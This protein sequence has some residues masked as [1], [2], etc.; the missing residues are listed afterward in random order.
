VFIRVSRTLSELGLATDELIEV[1]RS[2]S[3]VLS[4][5]AIASAH[6]KLITD[7]HPSQFLA[8]WNS[9]AYAK[10]HVLNPREGPLLPNGDRTII[11]DLVIYDH[12]LI[13][14]ILDGGLRELSAGY[15][16]EYVE[17][18]DS[19]LEQR[20]IRINHVAFVPN[21]RCGSACRVEDSKEQPMK[22]EDRESLEE[23]VKLIRELTE[24]LSEQQRTQDCD[25]TGQ[26]ED[27]EFRRKVNSVDHPD[28]AF[29]ERAREFH[30]GGA[31][32]PLDTPRTVAN[33]SEESYETLIARYRRQRWGL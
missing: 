24:I 27:R 8:P 29:G 23:A 31:P 3:E 7:G 20:Q 10:G 1:Y 30:R 16:T 26:T 15:D 25:S 9:G 28:R 22:K 19:S 6:G 21:G 32:S 4:K 14:K 5:A 12:N 13:S 18:S 11:A 33:D 17:R 2:P